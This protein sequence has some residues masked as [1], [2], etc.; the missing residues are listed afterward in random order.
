MSVAWRTALPAPR[1]LTLPDDRAA[2]RSLRA[3]VARL[4]RELTDLGC[5]VWPRKGFEFGVSARGG[6]RLLSLAELEEA[7]DALASRIGVARRELAARTEAEELN[8]RSIEEMLCDP[9][10]HRWIRVRHD[11]I[12]EPGCL[13]YHVRP[14]AGLLGML[15]GW[16]R[17]VISSGCPL[18]GPARRSIKQSCPTPP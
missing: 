11:D 18:S 1:P 9:A 16:W 13:S 5:S 7:R 4:E 6:A 8:R 17:V 3:Q 15:A 2:R 10:A 12:G 14:R